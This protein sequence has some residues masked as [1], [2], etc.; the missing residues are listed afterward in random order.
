[1]G[2]ETAEAVDK[3]EEDEL[4]D[5]VVAACVC[6]CVCVCLCNVYVCVCV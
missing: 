1:M 5:G 2:D 4:P 3:E 6:V